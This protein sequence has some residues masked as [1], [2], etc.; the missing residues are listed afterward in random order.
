MYLKIYKICNKK[1]SDSEHVICMPSHDYS[2][3]MAEMAGEG[4]DKWVVIWTSENEDLLPGGK[5]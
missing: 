1:R 2:S 4:I 3:K 5:R